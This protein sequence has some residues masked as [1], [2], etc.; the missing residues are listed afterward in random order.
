[1]RAK[2]ARNEGVDI[3][4]GVPEEEYED[5]RQ[6][7]QQAESAA[8]D[9]RIENM[10]LLDQIKHLSSQ[11]LTAQTAS[12]AVAYTPSAT[13]RDYGELGAGRN[14]PAGPRGRR[15]ISEQSF[16]GTPL[17]K[18]KQLSSIRSFSSN[19][20]TVKSPSLAGLD[21]VAELEKEIDELKQR[22]ILDETLSH[23]VQELRERVE[24]LQEELIHVHEAKE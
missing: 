5:E 1:M 17:G 18:L 10:R 19:L 14:G 21:R 23:E 6:K 24:A 15:R 16:M 22:P 20:E 9:Y 2:L 8:E 11:V 7:R 12:Q 4:M 3:S 13:E